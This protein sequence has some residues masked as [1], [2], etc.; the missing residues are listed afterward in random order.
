MNLNFNPPQKKMCILVYLPIFLFSHSFTYI[1]N[2]YTHTL[3][4]HT[5]VT[6]NRYCSKYELAYLKKK[7]KEIYLAFRNCRYFT[8]KLFK[9]IKENVEDSEENWSLEEF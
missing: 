1:L 8:L 7:M 4:I 6:D 2:I 5:F 3:Y 9:R